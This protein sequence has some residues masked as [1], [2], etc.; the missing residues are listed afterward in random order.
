[1]KQINSTR[2][3]VTITKNNISKIAVWCTSAWR[4]SPL[5]NTYWSFGWQCDLWV[6]Y[7]NIH[8]AWDNHFGHYGCDTIR[9]VMSKN[10]QEMAFRISANIITVKWLQDIFYKN[11]C[12]SKYSRWPR[13]KHVR[14]MS[15]HTQS[16]GE[17]HSHLYCTRLRPNI[18]TLCKTVYPYPACKIRVKKT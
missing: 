1:M 7:N 13:K 11:T 8:S 2:L 9:F 10:S 15:Q 17:Y 5:E 14:H 3:L 6:G 18:R 16:A 12:L 4:G